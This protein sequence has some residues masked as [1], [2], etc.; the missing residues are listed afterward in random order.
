MQLLAMGVWVYAAEGVANQF[1]S[2]T[3]F[4]HY[5]FRDCTNLAEF[6]LREALPQAGCHRKLLPENWRKAALALRG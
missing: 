1:C 2:T 5:L 4:G 6:N 3:K